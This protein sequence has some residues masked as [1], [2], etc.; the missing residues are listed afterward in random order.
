MVRTIKIKVI[1]YSYH[2]SFGILTGQFH[3]A[4]ASVPREIPAYPKTHFVSV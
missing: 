2:L 3:N 1:E 4:N